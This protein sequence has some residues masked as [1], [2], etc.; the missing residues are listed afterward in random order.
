MSEY[1]NLSPSGNLGFDIA[2]NNIEE[3][4][5]IHLNAFNSALTTSFTPIWDFGT[6]FEFIG[7]PKTLLAVSTDAADTMEIRINGIDAD[8]E[9]ISEDITLAGLTPVS[10]TLEYAYINSVC[11]LSSCN[12]GNISLYDDGITYAYIAAE[13]GIT[14]RAMFTVPDNHSLYLFRVTM[15]S[16]TATGSQYIEFRAVQTNETGLCLRVAN[17]TFAHSQVDYNFQIPFKIPERTTFYIEAKTSS[18]NNEIGAFIE[19]VLLRNPWGR[20]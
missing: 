2:R 10:T 20:E 3:A 19:G 1:T 7:S 15:N 12:A 6:T 8:Y 17:A 16:A 18:G 11:I 9:E 4:R 5:A 14:H 13:L